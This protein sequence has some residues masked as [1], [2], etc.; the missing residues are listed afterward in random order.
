MKMQE[1]SNYPVRS[2]LI[3]SVLSGGILIL[4]DVDTGKSALAWRLVQL[5]AESQG[6]VGWIDGDIGQSSLGLPA[7]T[8]LALLNEPAEIKPS[9]RYN[10]LW[11]PPMPLAIFC[12]SSPA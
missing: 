1:I 4:G 9:P 11:A 3:P 6:P 12:P 10:F 7:T 2:E 8:N 5:L